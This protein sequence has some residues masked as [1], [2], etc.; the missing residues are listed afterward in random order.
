MFDPITTQMED[1]LQDILESK[2][3]SLTAQVTALFICELEGAGLTR[4]EAVEIVSRQG[5]VKS[6]G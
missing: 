5:V 1:I 4:E 2:V 3:L 6:N